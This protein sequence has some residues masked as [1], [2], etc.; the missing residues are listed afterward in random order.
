MTI[1][2]YDCETTTRTSFGRKANPFDPRNW[3]VAVGRES[4]LS[5][6]QLSQYNKA[7]MAPG[8]FG[9]YLD[10]VRLLVGHN[11]KF[12]ILHA[13]ARDEQNRRAWKKWVVDGG[14]LWDTQLAEYL[15]E[16]MHQES[17]MLSLNEVAVKYGGNLKVD[18]VALL[19]EAGVDTPDIDE[20]LLMRYLCGDAGAGE[21]G[22]LGNTG[23]VL[24]GQLSRLRADGNTQLASV[25]LNMLSL[26]ASIEMEYNGIFVDR[27]MA[28]RQRETLLVQIAEAQKEVNAYLPDDLPFEFNWGS[29]QHK[30]AIIFGGRVRYQSRAYV[31]EDGST[32]FVDEVP[33]DDPRIRY[34]KHTVTRYMVLGAGSDAVP[35]PCATDP[36]PENATRFLSGKRIGEAVTKNFSEPDITKP[37]TRMEDRYYTFPRLTEPSKAWEGSTPG[38]YSTSADVIKAL[39]NRGIPFLAKMAELSKLNKDISTYYY[40]TDADG[41]PDKGMMTFIMPDGIVHH[42]VN[43][44]STVTGRFAHTKPN[45]GNQPKG[46]K[47]A[48]KQTFVSRFEDGVIIQDDFTSLEVYA[49]AVLTGDENLIADLLKGV[50]MHVMRVAA[51]HGRPYEELLPLCKGTK[52]TDPDPFWKKERQGAKEFSFQR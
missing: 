13:I 28:E 1:G 38:Q 23:V 44:T 24:R 7:P 36:V 43:H 41:N 15:L 10:G 8:W 51:K 9:K 2:I 50:D 21:L 4:F 49:Q 34:A 18:E 42:N 30:S 6:E 45:F 35:G 16:G 22:D 27:E 52:D 31:F 19:W 47:S 40:T 12:D 14:R 37:K 17:Q 46:D 29:T 11:I 32:A 33:V 20:D 39:A 26:I 25:R 5:G 3:V 48:I